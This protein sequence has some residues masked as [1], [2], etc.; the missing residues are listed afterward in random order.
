M[1]PYSTKIKKLYCYVDE[2]GQETRGRFFL[3]SVI[4]FEKERDELRK[5]LKEIEKRSGKQTKKWAK[6]KLKQREEYIKQIINSDISQNS[7]YY[8]YYLNTQAYVDL[9]IFSTAKAVHNKAKFPYEAIIF[10]DGLRRTERFRFGAGL[11]E[12]KVKVKKVRGIKDESDEFIRLADAIAGF[13]RDGLEKNPAMELLYKKA[14]RN[15][16]IKKI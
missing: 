13:V 10:V 3:V 5:K 14:E 9:T 6:A 8:S 15:K 11:R 4:I 16:V 7:I 1:I 2:T 12:L